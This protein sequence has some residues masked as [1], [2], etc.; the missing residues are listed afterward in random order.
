MT[1]MSLGF[2]P[3][4]LLLAISAN[5]V[6]AFK[7]FTML[8]NGSV[9][10][11][12]LGGTLKI[13]HFVDRR[14]SSATTRLVGGYK[15]KR[16]QDFYCSRAGSH[17]L[18]YLCHIDKLWKTSPQDYSKC[19]PLK[20]LTEGIEQLSQL[21]MESTTGMLLY[22]VDFSGIWLKQNTL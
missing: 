1:I 17:Y 21:S 18:P 16:D 10:S 7:C 20:R 15:I 2:S 13:F 4:P 19:E 5:P 11:L 6:K 9:G 3:R 8:R 22:H 14:G 12:P